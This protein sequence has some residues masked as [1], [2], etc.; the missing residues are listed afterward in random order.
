MAHGF[1]QTLRFRLIEIVVLENGFLARVRALVYDD[2][3]AF[4]RRQA[5][6]VGGTLEVMV[7]FC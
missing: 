3:S 4:M 1:P 6:D 7:F 5:A 2:A